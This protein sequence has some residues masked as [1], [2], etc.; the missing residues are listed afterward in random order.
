M[1][2]ITHRPPGGP[3]ILILR[4]PAALTASFGW[5]VAT[6]AR[7]ESPEMAGVSH[8]LEHMVFKGTAS[9][10]ADAINREL[11]HL[12][13][14]S[15]AYTSEDRTVFYASVIPECQRRVV[16][17]LTDLMQPSLEAEQFDLERQVI[18]EEIAMYEDQPPYGAF[19]RANELFFG[20]HPL[21]T[22]VLGT[23]E[24]VSNMT[25]EQM[26]QYHR[27][28]YTR[29]NMIFAA[30]GMVD[31][32]DL[33]EQIEGMVQDWP[34]TAQVRPA[35]AP[36]FLAGRDVIER[37]L[38]HQHYAVMVWPG[39]DW[40]HADRYALK[41]LCSVLADHGSSRMFWALIDNGLAESVSL[42]P[43][44]FGDCGCITGFLCCAPEDAPL[45]EDTF[46]QVLQGL[47]E[48]PIEH[49][50]L[51]LAKNRIESHLVMSDE[52]PSNRMFML[53]NA[54]LERGEYL[55]LEAELQRL[56]AVQLDDIQR[57]A[58][59]LT[60]E[61]LVRVEV[62]EAQEAGGESGG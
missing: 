30:S 8:F 19:E 62:V 27:Q 17:L 3:D 6:G 59:L 35:P 49:R 44:Y 25:V 29:D 16:D 58:A 51:N 42:Y 1:E 40:H 14:H 53:G 47:A 26:R 38:T 20:T 13:A 43:Q 36:A 9:R 28:R 54:W 18:L 2:L 5:F 61:P 7:D 52:Y 39:L 57:M 22:R 34:A 48:K 23:A 60:K 56:A 15:N 46:Y 21:A 45:V 12:G 32:D 55:S 10:S 24:T 37:E 33:I 50:E 11:D 41:L 4:D 31:V